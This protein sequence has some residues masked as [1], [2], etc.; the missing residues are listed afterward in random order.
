VTPGLIEGS[1]A[2]GRPGT[3]IVEIVAIATA[4][5]MYRL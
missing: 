4:A 5:R 2:T 3:P 1:A